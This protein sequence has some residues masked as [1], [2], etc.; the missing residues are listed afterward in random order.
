MLYTVLVYCSV[1]AYEHLLISAKRKVQ[2]RLMGMSLVLQVFGHKPNQTFD[3]M[4]ALD[5]MSKHRQSYY[6]SSWGGHECVCHFMA[7]HPTLKWKMGR[8]QPSLCFL[9]NPG[10]VGEPV[11]FFLGQVWLTNTFEKIKRRFFTLS[12]SNFIL[13][14]IRNGAH[15]IWWMSRFGLGCVQSTVCCRKLKH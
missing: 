8:R 9:L 11:F 12:S 7:S 5:K 10:Q 1:L 2:L 14:T 6:N 13:T 15:W 3:L 4:M